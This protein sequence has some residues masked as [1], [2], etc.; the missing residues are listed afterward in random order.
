MKCKKVVGTADTQKARSHVS[1]EGLLS[2]RNEI[3]EFE[4][5]SRDL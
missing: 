5:T 1:S 2:E 4:L 3:S